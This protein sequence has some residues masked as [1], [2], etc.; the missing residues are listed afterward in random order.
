MPTI[1][2]LSVVIDAEVDGFKHGIQLTK[3]QLEQLQTR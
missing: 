3:K 2:K 1:E